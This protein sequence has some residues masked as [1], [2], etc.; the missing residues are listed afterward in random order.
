MKQKKEK[1]PLCEEGM[2]Q[3]KK[4]TYSVYGEVLG[5]FPA[6][7]CKSCKEE[8]FDEKTSKEIEMIEKKKGLFGLSRKS[9]ISYSGN[10]LIVRIPESLAKFMHLQ[11]EKE[12][13]IYPEGKNKII[14]E[15]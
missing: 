2:L 15:I 9:K 7:F 13:M 1:C 5:E 10:S 8:W 6:R 3:Q 14:V 12:I 11:R 4:I